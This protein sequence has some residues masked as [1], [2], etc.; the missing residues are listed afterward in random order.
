MWILTLR[1]PSQRP[2]VYRI[3]PG[4]NTLGR[5]P[6]NDVIISDESASRRHCEIYSHDN[7]LV[8]TDLN[9]T[10][11]TFV[12][13]QRLAQPLVLRSG[14]QIRIGQQVANIAYKGDKNGAEL[15]SALLKT[16]PLTRELLLASVDQHAVLLYE[17]SSRLNTIL[18]LKTAMQEVSRL[19]LESMGADKC[20]VILAEAFDHLG[21]LGFPT[22]IAQQA[23]DQRSVV[24]IPDLTA[25]TEQ[26]PSQSALLLRI[27]S[28]LCVPVLVEDQTAALIYVYKTDPAARPFDENDVQLAVAIS[29]QTALTIQRSNLIERS[30]VLEENL[31]NDGLTGLSTRE[32]FMKRAELEFQRAVRFHHDMILIML[33]I[34]NFKQVNDNYGH[35]AGNQVLVELAVRCQKQVR[36]IDL[37][38]RFGGDEFILLLVETNA[39]DALTVAERIRQHIAAEPVETEKG[40]LNITVSLGLA[41]LGSDF[42]DLVALISSADSA[43]YEAKNFG[44]NRVVA[45]N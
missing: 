9:S 25:L 36:S 41:H 7:S 43:L 14:D 26:F 38:G 12:N 40:P 21:E 15:V 29:H 30:R 8:I 1:S 22:S 27:R 19:L 6:D 44:R 33:D 16:R 18:D 28:I 37:I 24:V 2:V 5:Q 20:E 34:D 39:G 13:R 11:G 31:N 45:A 17:I 4:K 23:I 3:R 35:I 10:N 42:L 32:Y